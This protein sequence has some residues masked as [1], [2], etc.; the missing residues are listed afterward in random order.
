[1]NREIVVKK[2][3]GVGVGTIAFVILFV[4]KLLGEIDMS[5]F[6][7]LT[8]W[9]WVPVLVLLSAMALV[10]GFVLIVGIIGALVSK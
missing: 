9:I 6:W 7:V 10:M 8:S 5:W 3:V 2:E 1:M 4:L